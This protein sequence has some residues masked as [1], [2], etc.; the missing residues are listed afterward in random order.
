MGFSVAFNNNFSESESTL[1]RSQLWFSGHGHP[2][3][4]HSTNGFITTK[5]YKKERNQGLVPAIQ[6]NS[7]L[8]EPFQ[9]NVKGSWAPQPIIKAYLTGIVN[10]YFKCFHNY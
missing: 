7:N 6:N 1:D 4:L 5:L 9:T 3:R 8:C 2:K 10:I